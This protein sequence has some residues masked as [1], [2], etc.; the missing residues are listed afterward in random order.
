[1]LFSKRALMILLAACMVLLFPQLPVPEGLTPEGMQVIG[2]FLG[3]LVL[4]LTISVDWPS[5]LC[6]L[7]LGFV[8]GLD[9]KFIFANSFGNGVF[10]FLMFTFLCTH[11]LAETPF[12]KRCATAFITSNMAQKGP[13]Y[14]TIS[15]FA[16]LLFI[17][18][19]MSPTVLFLIS[20]PMLEEIYH[21]LG[22]KKGHSLG[23]MLLIGTAFCVSISAGMTPIA[24][25]F[26]IMCMGVYEAMTGQTIGYAQYIMTAVPVGIACAAALLGILRFLMNP[27][28]KPL[29]NLDFAALKAKVPPVTKKEIVVVSIFVLVVCLWIL[30]SLLKSVVPFL[31]AIDKLGPAFPPMIGIILYSIITID[32]KPLLNFVEAMKQGVPWPSVVLAAGTLVLG[33]IMSNPKIGIANFFFSTLSP[34]LDVLSPILL[35]IFLCLLT[36]IVTNYSTNMI[37][38]TVVITVAVSLGLATEGAINTPALVVL[39]GSLAAYAFATPTSLPHIGITVGTGWTTTGEVFKYGSLFMIVTVLLTVLVGYPIASMLL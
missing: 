22:V 21:M 8:P 36:G 32:G 10:L 15:Y 25:V 33:M 18:S 14:F 26:S 16:S 4:W 29:E 7:L 39:I 20:F 5:I 2:I 13:W 30:P 28:M 23:S 38:V 9:Y 1:M 31:G 3:C 34:V 37:T 27:D 11:T 35:V 19:F 17:G 12:L 6:I 24:H